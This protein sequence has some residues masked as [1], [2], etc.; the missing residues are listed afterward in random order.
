MK[1]M[2]ILMIVILERTTTVS[3]V[4]IKFVVIV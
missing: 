3:N 2:E 4:D 1:I